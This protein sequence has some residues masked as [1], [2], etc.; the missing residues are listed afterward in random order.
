MVK[1][2][3]PVLLVALLVTAVYQSACAE[4]WVEV[5][6]GFGGKIRSY[7]NKDSI[8]RNGSF[9]R[10]W[11]RIFLG[12]SPDPEDD[13]RMENYVLADCQSRQYKLLK[14][15]DVQ[16][17]ELIIQPESSQWAKPFRDE[18]AVPIDYVCDLRF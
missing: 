18:D 14:T 7:V 1:Q 9:A 16:T 6:N 17:G 15:R 4:A 3:V 5:Y 11:T 10:F 8:T 2:I 12:T 13:T